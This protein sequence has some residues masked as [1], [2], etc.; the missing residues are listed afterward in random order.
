MPKTLQDPTV[1]LRGKAED[2][3][4]PRISPDI[5]LDRIESRGTPT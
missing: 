2:L 1:G 4:E 5:A 3:K